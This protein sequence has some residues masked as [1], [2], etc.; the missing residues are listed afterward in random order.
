MVVR[1]EWGRLERMENAQHQP[2]IGRNFSI[3][4]HDGWVNGQIVVQE[5][6]DAAAIAECESRLSLLLKDAIK[7]LG[8]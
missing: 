8:R 1:I 2:V 6:T 4:S 7:E 5:T 3:I